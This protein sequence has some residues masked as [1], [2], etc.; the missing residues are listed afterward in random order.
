MKLT[1]DLDKI[2]ASNVSLREIILDIVTDNPGIPV[3]KACRTIATL[4][5]CSIFSVTKIFD[6]MVDEDIIHVFDGPYIQDGKET[7]VACATLF[8]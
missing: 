4:R 5:V 1:L 8:N 6:E 7:I 3:K 2:N